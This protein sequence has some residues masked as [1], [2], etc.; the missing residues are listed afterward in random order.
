MNDREE[1]MALRRLAELEAKAGQSSQP[2]AQQQT[3]PKNVPGAGVVMG[4]ADPVYG[5]GQMVPRGLSALTSLGGLAPNPVSRAYDRSAGMIDTA[6]QER[7]KQYQAGRDSESF[8]WGRLTGNVLSPVNLIGAG[9]A[10]SAAAAPTL[11]TKAAAGAGVGAGYASMAPV[12]SE[13]D[14]LSQKANQM[15]WGAGGGL[16]AP[17]IGSAIG[18]VFNPNTDD[19]VRGLLKEGVKLTPGE[20]TGGM[21]KRGEDVLSS[22]PIAG[23]VVKGAQRRSIE[24]LNKAAYNRVLAPIGQKL[25]NNVELGRDAVSYV[26]RELGKRYDDLLPKLTGQID[27]VFQQ[28]MSNVYKMV[29]I[30]DI[31][32]P[33]E[34]A[35]FNSIIKNSIMSR[36]SGNGTMTGQAIKDI[37]SELG[38]KAAVFGKGSIQEQQ[39]ADALRETQN[40]LRGLVQ[41]SNPQYADELKA[42]NTGW[43]NFKRVQNAVGSLG[44]NE[45]IFSPP[46]LQSAVKAL[47]KSKDK[48]AFARGSALMQ[49]LSD[50]AKARMAQS[51]PNSGS[52]DRLLGTAL[53]YGL[54]SGAAI[55]PAAIP[56][57]IA[58]MGYVPGG[59][60]IA[61]AILADRPQAVRQLG[62]AASKYAPYLSAPIAAPLARE[63]GK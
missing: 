37:E 57:G 2:E 45:G 43:A 60:R 38:E 26:E 17:I 24:S 47:D 32:N 50:P 62:S 52:V 36:M 23:S 39:L 14:F 51:V 42:I 33:P 11:A 7:E 12:T 59:R 31:M 55:S 54:A 20:I 61:Q 27:N 30:D 41:R 21:L 63:K 44:A 28:D 1:L 8:D 49:D 35:K 48:A 18:R 10:R 5:I 46:Q 29:Q 56:M 22:V 53:P 3:A 13:G 19:A 4:A 16:A 15:A 58:A 25:P 9:A 34:K 40:V 6:V